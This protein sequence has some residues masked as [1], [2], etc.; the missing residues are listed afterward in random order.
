M[1]ISNELTNT[2]IQKVA[3]L[4]SA[5]GNIGM[6]VSG[7]GEAACNANSGNVYLWLEDYPFCLYIAPC[8]EWDIWVNWTDSIDGEEHE[9]PLT[10][11]KNLQA[12]YDWCEEL[13]KQSD[14]KE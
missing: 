4:I 11:F 2:E 1:Q 13:Q 12:I 7:Y 5:A 3:A 9:E 10:D 14:A 8:G 6:D